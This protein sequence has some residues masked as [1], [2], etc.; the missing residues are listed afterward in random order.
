MGV[1]FAEASIGYGSTPGMLTM[2][3]NNGN[4]GLGSGKNDPGGLLKVE[5]KMGVWG[6]S[7]KMVSCGKFS[8]QMVL[9]E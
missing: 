4:G 9:Q 6:L 1:V 5:K 7:T 8:A 2:A 3:E